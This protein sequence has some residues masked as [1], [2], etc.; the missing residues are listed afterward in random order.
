MA[1]ITNI[2]QR[3]GLA[4][5]VVAVALG[6]FIV[7][8]DLFTA[9]SSIL[10][11]NDNSVG[12]IAGEDISYEFYQQQLE[13]LKYNFTVNFRRNPTENEMFSLRQQAWDL[14]IVKTAFQEQ[15]EELGIQVTPEEQIDMVQG[16]NINPD[17]KAAFTDPATGEFMKE[18]LVGYLK[19][20]DQRSPNEQAAWYLFEQGL[21][22]A[23]LRFKYDNLLTQS[24]FVTDAEAEQ[25][26]EAENSTADLKYIYVNY[27]AISDSL[28]EAPTDSELKAYLKEHSEDFKVEESRDL[29]Y[30]S[31]PIQPSGADTA[32][33]LNEL[34]KIKE[35]FRNTEED[36]IY[37]KINTDAAGNFFASYTIDQLPQSLQNNYS[38]LSE[39]DVRGPYYDQGNINLYKISEITEDTIFAA[40]A[41]HILI[42]WDDESAQAKAEARSKAN[43][44]LRRALSGEDFE[45]LAIQNSQ[46]PGSAVQGGSLGWFS[47]GKMV[48]PFEEAVFNARREGVI[49]RLIESQFGFHII[50]VEE[51]KDNTLFKVAVI[52]RE[53]TAS[54]ETRNVAYKKAD[55]IAGTSDDYDSFKNNIERD[56]LILRRAVN[57]GKNDRRMNNL[58]NARTVIQWAYRDASLG[59]VSPVFELDDAYVVAVLTAVQEEGTADLEDV[60]NQVETK[61]KNQKKGELIIEKLTSAE[62]ETLEQKAESFGSEARVYTETS[63]KLSSNTITNVGFVPEAVGKAFGMEIGEVS[64]PFKVENGVLMLELLNKTEAGEIADY[65]SYQDRIAQQM[66]SRLTFNAAEAI[67][68]AANIEDRRY[69]FY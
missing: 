11:K 29:E 28:I 34:E 13:E 52:T 26:Y 43:N 61:V 68:E 32:F 27:G 37:A 22:P 31:I 20:L 5:G 54:D 69:K 51:T 35:D 67:K 18:R 10:G 7:G 25:L 49:G 24:T 6:L 12:T 9:N 50:N 30:I 16:D 19:S 59:E 14:V 36:S 17:I 44:I 53:I 8:T 45:Q 38:N 40:K 63:L 2:R 41:S 15:Y 66:N 46:D 33:F 1:L 60:R 56:S 4:V 58:S 47:K 55:Y 21:T 64:Q 48:P 42:K 65:T 23:R 57:L 3:A 39:G 62:G